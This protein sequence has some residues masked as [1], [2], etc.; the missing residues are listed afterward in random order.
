MF[1]TAL[2]SLRP[3]RKGFVLVSTGLHAT[4]AGALILPPM[5]RMPDLGAEPPDR[6]PKWVEILPKPNPPEPQ[7]VATDA[8][9][10]T[11][12]HLPT[13]VRV[14]TVPREIPKDLPL[15]LHESERDDTREVIG[16]VPHEAEEPGDGPIVISEPP[17]DDPIPAGSPDVTAPIAISTPPPAYPEGPRVAGMQGMVILE[18]V[19]GRDGLVRDVRVLRGVNPLFDRAASEAVLKWRYR[20]ALVGTRAVAVYLTVTVNFQ[21]HRG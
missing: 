1:E 11:R 8:G 17:G 14:V 4:L 5:L 19:I 12:T 16:L 13:N 20:P 21:I 7:R 6:M 18:A 15:A 10:G 3:S 2:A 9:R